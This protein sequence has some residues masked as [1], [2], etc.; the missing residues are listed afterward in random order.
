MPCDNGLQ[1]AKDL[2][3][4]AFMRLFPHIGKFISKEH[5][6]FTPQAQ[7]YQTHQV[8]CHLYFQGYLMTERD[9]G[10]H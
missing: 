2:V 10:R 8:Q 9:E 6:Q 4:F 7:H 5:S 1:V 3:T